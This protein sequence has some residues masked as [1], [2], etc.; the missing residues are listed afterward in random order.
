MQCLRSHNSFSDYCHSQIINNHTSRKRMRWN[1]NLQNTFLTHHLICVF[2]FMVSLC[3]NPKLSWSSLCRL[4]LPWT[5]RE[6]PGSALSVCLSSPPRVC[7][8]ECV[9][10]CVCVVEARGGIRCPSV[11]PP[12]IPHLVFQTEPLTDSESGPFGSMDLSASF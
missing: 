10:V 2:V 6:P 1:R 3:S 11:I 8:C 12:V 9:S 7:E 5:Q 4:G